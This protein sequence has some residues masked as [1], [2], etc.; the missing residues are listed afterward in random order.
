M[1]KLIIDSHCH[2]W[3]EELVLKDLHDYIVTRAKLFGA[4]PK[5]VL[6][7]SAERLVSE[8]DSTG[9]DKTVILA[10]DFEFLFRGQITFQEYDD[11]VAEMVNHFPKMMGMP[12]FS[13]KDKDKILGK[14]TQKIFQ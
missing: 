4:D 14:N 3:E 13:A 2:V 8:M 6:D 12:E 1:N 10:L 9:I 7:E 5:L 11:R